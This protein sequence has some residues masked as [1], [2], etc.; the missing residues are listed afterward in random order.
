STVYNYIIIQC[1]LFTKQARFL[2]IERD[3]K[4]EIL[5]KYDRSYGLAKEGLSCNSYGAFT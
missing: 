1:R 2:P 3:I 5:Q 4:E